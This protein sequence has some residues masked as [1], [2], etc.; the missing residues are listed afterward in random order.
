MSQPAGW[1]P[2]PENLDQL[3]Y[4]DGAAWTEHRAPAHHG[5]GTAPPVTSRPD[6]WLW[7]SI[8]A[9][10]FCC[11]PFGVVAIVYAAQANSA[12]AAGNW[13][14]AQRQAAKARQWTLISVAAAGVMAVG[15]LLLIG[16]ASAS[17]V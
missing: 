13:A 7:Q 11:L 10:L 4:W 17:P 5:T 1:Y 9:T 12:I 6:P 14:E 16:A 2:D 3:R 15:W 8:L